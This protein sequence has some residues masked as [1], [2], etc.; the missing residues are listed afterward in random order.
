MII[1]MRIQYNMSRPIKST[2]I[3]KGKDAE[4]LIRETE[5][6]KLTPEKK[7]E[8]EKCLSLYHKFFSH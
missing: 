8:L 2:P 5:R 1:E 7:K 3:L 6:I 4:R